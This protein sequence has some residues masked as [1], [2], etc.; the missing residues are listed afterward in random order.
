MKKRQFAAAVS[1]VLLLSVCT[2]FPAQAEKTQ[3][4]VTDTESLIAALADAK[5]GDEIVVRE[6]LYQNDKNTGKWA[7]FWAEASGTADRHIILRSEDPAHP[8][9]LSGVSQEH[10]YALNI[11]GSYWEIRDLRLTN[12]G[13]GLFLSK[14]EHSL[15]SG[16]EVYDIGDEG[17]HIIDDSS[18][19]TVENCWIHDTGTVEARY[20]EGVYIG[21][22]KGTANYGFECHY[23]TVRG[24]RFGPNIAADHVDIKEYTYGNLVEYCT[25]DGTGMK[26]ENG[27]N[28]FVEIKGNDAVVRYNTGYRNGAEKQ[29]YGFDMNEQI[30]GWGQGTKIYDNKLFLD[31]SEI[32]TVKGWNCSAEVFRNIVEPAE[33][34]VYGNKITEILC[35]TLAGDATGDGLL[36]TEDAERLRDALLTQDVPYLDGTNSDLN[37]NGMLNAADLTRLKQRLLQKTD[38]T[39]LLS[40]AFVKEGAGKWRMT[41]G[42]GGRTLTFTMTAEPESELNLAWGYWDPNAASESTGSTGQWNN[43]PVGKHKADENGK[44]SLE[45]EVPEN[46]TRVALQIWGISGK[47]GKLDP[48]TV[49]LD[50]V[51]TQ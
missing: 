4:L 9:T 25:F 13:K 15:V 24:C 11:I 18:Y 41:E 5:A 3:I 34:T 21:S 17:I 10:K 1:A 45:A 12:A 50:S 16:C 30:E 32:Y 23:N 38:E 35:C 47:S 22:A 36:C 51:T 8:A 26:G 29:L 37:V 44:V 40:V 31:S 6:G 27:G 39:P 49:T 19:N 14:S 28:S 20:G 7:A 42:L 46:C 33:C 48:D 43:V 2:A